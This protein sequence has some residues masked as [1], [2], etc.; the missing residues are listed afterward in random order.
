MKGGRKGGRKGMME[1]VTWILLYHSRLACVNILPS[2]SP[3]SL[4]SN[5]AP[6]NGH[7]RRREGGREGGEER[8]VTHVDCIYTR[9]DLFL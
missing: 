7:T 1:L 9:V 8:A 3:T 2:H 4:H 5:P 6:P